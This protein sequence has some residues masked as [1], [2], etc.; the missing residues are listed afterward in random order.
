MTLPNYLLGWTLNQYYALLYRDKYPDRVHIVRT[1]DV[2][3][4]SRK[5][6][7]AV[8]EELGLEAA[9]SLSQVTWNGCELKEVYPWGAI[10]TPTPEVNL[11][12]ARE[13]NSTQIEEI[14]LRA[15]PYLETFDYKSFL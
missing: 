13:L 10:R 14:R 7:G 2:M 5:T 3:R 4:D 6:L 11:A 15:H 1:E 9:D 8:C 12:T